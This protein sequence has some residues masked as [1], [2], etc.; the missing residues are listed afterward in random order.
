M[1]QKVS[2]LADFVKAFEALGYVRMVDVRN[3][4]PQDILFR[5]E[6]STNDVMQFASLTYKPRQDAYALRIGISNLDAM[7]ALK[8]V[9]SVLDPYL[10]PAISREDLRIWPCWTM[11]NA[12]R[13]LKWPFVSIPDPRNRRAWQMQLQAFAERLLPVFLKTSSASGILNLLLRDDEPFDW[14]ATNTVL[15]TAEVVALNR[16]SHAS[17]PL[18]RERLSAVEPKIPRDLHGCKDTARFI[19]DLARALGATT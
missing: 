9:V 10:H 19:D 11:F 14:W 15:R 16:V 18:T 2:V 8:D 12:G 5:H 7:I 17:W 4:D 1:M 3:T 13:A 6:S